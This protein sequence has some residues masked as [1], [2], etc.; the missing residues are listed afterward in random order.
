[1]VEVRVAIGAMR[2]FVESVHGYPSG[3]VGGGTIDVIAK[4]TSFFFCN[5]IVKFV[6]RASIWTLNRGLQR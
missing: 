2:L 5:A 3:A 6:Y 1:M 4:Q